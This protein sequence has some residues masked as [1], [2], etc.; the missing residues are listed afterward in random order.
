MVGS[1][2]L[3][4]F[5]KERKLD[6]FLDVRTEPLWR[7]TKLCLFLC[8]C[9][10]FKTWELKRGQWSKEAN[11]SSK[12]KKKVSFGPLTTVLLNSFKCGLYP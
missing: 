8:G 11:N 10:W 4:S 5:Y 7:L 12:L 6:V 9:S 3:N 1:N 2:H